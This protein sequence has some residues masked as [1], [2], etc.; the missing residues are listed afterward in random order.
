MDPLFSV[1]IPG[2]RSRYLIASVKSGT[3]TD[4]GPSVGR[5]AYGPVMPYRLSRWVIFAPAIIVLITAGLIDNNQTAIAQG[6]PG[7]HP[8]PGAAAKSAGAAARSAVA[9]GTGSAG[10]AA[11][12]AAAGD[13]ALSGREDAIAAIPLSRLTPAAQQRITS[14]THRP[15]LYRHLSQQ[16]IQCDPELFLFI[17][18]HPEILVGI[19]DLMEIT[20]VQTERVGDYQLRAIDGSGTDCTV[21]LVYGDSAVHVYVADG[22]YDGKLT[23]NPVPGKGVFVLRC[24]HRTNAVGNPVVEGTL[25]CFV[26]VDHL[27]ADLLIRTFGPLIGRTAD[28]NF[29]ETAR[30]IDQLG[31]S[32]R[33]HPAAMEELAMRL[34]Q[35]SAA[36]RNQFAAVVRQSAE[37]HHRAALRR[38]DI[39]RASSALPPLAG[40]ERTTAR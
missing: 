30:F 23:A 32:A 15:T 9:E 19:W 16:T 12:R 21:D 14:I 10:R 34:P 26:Q 8:S 35:V 4:G 1:D 20:Q 33:K 40:A 13:S 25:D 5:N 18:R 2:Q 28:N 3:A 24:Q 7:Y 29:S 31:T 37:R 39:S 6:H 17:V 11:Q 22:F 38:G 36:T 27:A